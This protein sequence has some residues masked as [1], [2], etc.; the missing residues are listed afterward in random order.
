[1][2][3]VSLFD[4]LNVNKTE[5]EITLTC[6]DSTLPTDDCNLI[7]K[8]AKLF[9]SEF[10]IKGG[11]VFNLEK[12]IPAAAGLGGGSSN[13]ASALIA[14][15]K[16]YDTSLTEEQICLLG[17]KIGSDVPFCIVGGT[18]YIYG[19]GD[20]YI[21]YTG[22]PMCY[23]VIS[24]DK[25]RILTKQAFSELDKKQNREIKS[26]DKMQKAITELNIK[27]IA[28]ELYNAFEIVSEYD[29]TIKNIMLE[30]GAAG[31][32]MSGSGP[33]VFGIFYDNEKASKAFLKL[34]ACGYTS[35]LCNPK[36]QDE[37]I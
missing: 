12:K 24:I 29:K 16:L 20:K 33:S 27:N 31:V 19:T 8:A 7:L 35:F 11:A 25:K 4:T 32:C 2:Q 26:I 37:L 10:N 17:S 1:M 6:D 3:S 23:I 14:L 13:A 9:F 5:S 15:N 34:T 18:C 30:C 36:I 28:S 21:K 22:I